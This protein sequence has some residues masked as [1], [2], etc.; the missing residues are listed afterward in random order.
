MFPGYP[1]GCQWTLGLDPEK[2]PE[3]G[4][5][6]ATCGNTL[7]LHGH[8]GSQIPIYNT[9]AWVVKGASRGTCYAVFDFTERFLEARYYM[10]THSRRVMCGTMRVVK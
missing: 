9:K 6:I 2:K 4:F 3:Q 1:V 5:M 10:G 8:D 7:V